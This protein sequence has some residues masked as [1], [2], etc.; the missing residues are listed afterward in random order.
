[1]D[2]RNRPTP[3]QITYFPRTLASSYEDE[4]GN[5]YLVGSESLYGNPLKSAWQRVGAPERWKYNFSMAGGRKE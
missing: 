2:F 5:I 3:N 4:N 1:M